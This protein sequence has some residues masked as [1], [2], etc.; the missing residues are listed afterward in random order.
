[1]FLV[2]GINPTRRGDVILLGEPGK[3]PS[4]LL[5]LA[6]GQVFL[7]NPCRVL[8]SIVSPHSRNSG[9]D[10]LDS[11]SKEMSLDL[12]TREFFAL[13]SLKGVNPSHQ[14]LSLFEFSLSQRLIPR[15]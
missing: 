12:Q 6:G 11:K 9:L 3:L 1:M 8:G 2:E 4:K 7:G 10:G 5:E 13:I 15:L 14:R